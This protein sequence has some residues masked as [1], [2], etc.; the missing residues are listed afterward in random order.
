VLADSFGRVH[1]YLRISLTERCNLRCFYC[2][3]PEGVQLSP[4]EHIMQA[5]EVIA[6]ASE[7]V[8]LGVNKI[9]LTG[10]EPLV[11]KDIAD[12]LKGLSALNVEIA[13][14]T[15]GVVLD[16]YMNLLE[17][18]NIKHLNISLDTLNEH[19]YNGIT[20]R[21]YFQRVYKNIN[22]A[23][24]RGFIVKVNVVLIKGKNEEE[25]IDF[26]EWTRN[27]NISVRFIEFMPFNGNNWDWSKGMGLNEIVSFLEKEYGSNLIKLEDKPHDTTRN[28]AIN[29]FKG[30][31]GVISTVTNPFCDSC[32]RIRLTANGRIRNCLF[33]AQETDLLGAL[34]S[35]ENI[36]MVIE[37]C[38]RNKKKVRGGMENNEQFAD[39]A[40]H[41]E[42]RSMVMIGG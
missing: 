11:R 14:S 36:R 16:Q 39:V 15:N 17:S 1:N 4:K 34:R 24:E 6:I 3:P 38:I 21:D 18:L 31:F 22:D 8:A 19:K 7:F 42:N 30:S 28:Y 23:I 35:G 27:K 2:M 5:N 32:N 40:N 20:Q 12:I 25:L 10:G 33:S 41:T 9:R 37:D 26:I 13:V 29:G